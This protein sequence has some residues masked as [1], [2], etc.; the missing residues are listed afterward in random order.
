MSVG[1]GLGP[2]I[3][4]LCAVVFA[5]IV[6]GLSCRPPDGIEWTVV[7]GVLWCPAG[8]LR[9]SYGISH[10]LH[11]FILLYLMMIAGSFLIAASLNVFGIANVLGKDD[12]RQRI[13]L[14]V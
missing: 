9:Y 12:N 1:R 7:S 14:Y 11:A 13:N 10:G 3:M 4:L 5:P 2:G 6:V 8:E